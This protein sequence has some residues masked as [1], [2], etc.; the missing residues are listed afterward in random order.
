MANRVTQLLATYAE[1]EDLV[2]IGAF[3]QGANPHNDLAVRMNARIIEFLKQSTRSPVSVEQARTQLSELYATIEK[4]A[5]LIE[6]QQR[7]NTGAPQP[8]RRK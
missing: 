8:A 7:Q 5:R 2:N 3:T 4:E 6:A 1:L